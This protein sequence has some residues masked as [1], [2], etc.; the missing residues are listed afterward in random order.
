MP[1]YRQHIEGARDLLELAA[2]T[3]EGRAAVRRWAGEVADS[4]PEHEPPDAVPDP[5]AEW[6]A[7]QLRAAQQLGYENLALSET[8]RAGHRAVPGRPPGRPLRGQRP[9]PRTRPIV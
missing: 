6:R 2:Q 3:P 5:E 1:D 4:L 8:G 7:A 9:G